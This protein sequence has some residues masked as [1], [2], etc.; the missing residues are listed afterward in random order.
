MLF[1]SVSVVGEISGS[2]GMHVY[3]ISDCLKVLLVII[4]V[5]RSGVR[6]SLYISNILSAHHGNKTSIN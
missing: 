4:N 6:K 3:A 5:D 1:I 2:Y